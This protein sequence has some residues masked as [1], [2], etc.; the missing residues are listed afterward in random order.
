M[1]NF[2]TILQQN[3]INFTTSF[4]AQL[5]WSEERR[6]VEKPPSQKNPHVQNIKTGL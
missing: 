4:D 3:L 5:N 6:A 2:A 1:E